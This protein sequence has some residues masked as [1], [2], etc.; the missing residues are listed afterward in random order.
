MSSLVT[1]RRGDCFE[2]LGD[3]HGAVDLVVADPPYGSILKNAGWEDTAVYDHVGRL[4]SALLVEGGT[5]Y[6]WG[7]TGTYK[8]RP[9]FAWLARIEH[10]TDLVIH[11][12]LTWAKRRAYGVQ[13]NYLYCREECAML[14][15]A[16]PKPKTFHVP[17]LEEKRGYAGFNKDYPAKSEFKRRTNVWMDVPELFSGKIHAAEKPSRLAEIMIRASSNPGD[18]VVDP[19]AGSG[20]TGVALNAVGEREGILVEKSECAMH[21]MIAGG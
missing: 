16:R 14:V 9:F 21:P 17:L 7:G 1:V 15:K 12:V 2:V 11:N 4:V 20:S 8:H 19:F 5:A 3:V 6:V 18:L 10:D 13:D